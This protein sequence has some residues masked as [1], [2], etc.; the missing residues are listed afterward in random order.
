MSTPFP[1]GFYLCPTPVGNLDDITLRALSLLKASDL[2]LSEDTRHTGL[3]L[4]HF[5]I[6][7]KR[8]VSNHKFNEEK[9]LPEILEALAR[10]EVVALVSDAGTPL[11]S[12]PGERAVRAAIEAGH[13]VVSLPGPQALLPALTASGLPV[14]PFRFEGFL[15][16]RPGERRRLLQSLQKDPATLAFFESAERVHDVLG[17]ILAL[18]G[19]RDAVL[20]REIS[21][22]YETF[23][24]GTVQELLATF[25]ANPP[26]GECVLMVMGYRP[27]PPAEEDLEAWVAGALAGGATPAEIKDGAPRVGFSRNQAYRAALRIHDSKKTPQDR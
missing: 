22:R 27:A 7:G 18:L 25:L 13:P 5:G 19:D 2:I 8:L 21:K 4:T 14:I 24:R 3:L 20:A 17:D 15:P 10:G 12:D 16:R 1:P 6:E 26:R 11:L 23:Y 9:R